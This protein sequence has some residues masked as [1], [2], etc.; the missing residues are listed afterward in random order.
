MPLKWRHDLS[1]PS[2][3]TVG[4]P[5]PQV[6]QFPWNS[7]QVFVSLVVWKPNIELI[8]SPWPLHYVFQKP[9]SRSELPSNPS[10]SYIKT[11]YR[12]KSKVRVDNRE[13]YGKNRDEACTEWNYDTIGGDN[14]CH[15]D[16]EWSIVK[17]IKCLP[18]AI[19]EEWKA[20][21]QDLKE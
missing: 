3:S 1:P 19:S 20:N 5:S 4:P 8:R 14:V 16:N 15:N 7:H 18:L 21:T 12:A 13:M 2:S 11:W 10:L 9:L 17:L 6:T